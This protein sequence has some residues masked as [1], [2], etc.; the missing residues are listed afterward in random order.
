MPKADLVQSNFTG[1]QIS[2]RLY[3]R[4][5]TT[6]YENGAEL[7]RNV[8][9]HPHGGV[10]K[11][12]GTHFVNDGY[13]N[14]ASR[15]NE[16]H[17]RLVPFV[18]SKGD[19]YVLEYV[20]YT[21][22]SH[23]GTVGGV[24]R[25]YR[26]H[27]VLLGSSGQYEIQLPGPGASGFAF[28]LT[29]LV[30]SG[31]T[32]DISGQEAT[33]TG[34]RENNDGTKLY[35]VGNDSARI[36]EYEMSQAGD[37]STAV[38]SGRS[39]SVA[40]QAGDP[41]GIDW[42]DDGTKLFVASNANKQIHQYNLSTPF[43]ITTA[44]YSGFS[45]SV[46]AQGSETLQDVAWNGL[47]SKLY[48]V[49]SGGDTIH[50]YDIPDPEDISSGS[51]SGNVLDVSTEEGTP[52]GIAWSSDFSKLHVIGFANDTIFE[53]ELSTPGDISTASYSGNSMSIVGQDDQPTGIAWSAS[54]VRLYMI[55]ST[56]G[57]VYSYVNTSVPWDQ[58][59][60][61][62]MQIAQS[63]DVMY[64]ALGAVVPHKLLRNAATDWEFQAITFEDGPYLDVN[65]TDTTLDPSAATGTVNVV[66]S[67][68]EGI[69]DGQGFLS[70]DVGR[71]IRI[72]N[73]S[74]WGFGKITVVNSTTDVT[75]EVSDKEGYAAFPTSATKDWRLGAWSDT[76][77]YPKKISFHQQ[78]LVFSNTDDQPN[79]VWMS[80]T[81]DF[82]N[83]SPTDPDGTVTDSH[84]VTY[85]I[86]A[87]VVDEIRWLSSLRVLGVGT[88][89]SEFSTMGE[90]VRSPVTPAAL[91]V[92]RETNLGSSDVVPVIIDNITVFVTRT[93]RRVVGWVYNFQQDSYAI[94]DLTIYSED[95]AYP[96]IVDIAYQSEPDSI[97][98]AIRSDGK[99]LGLTYMPSQ[100][101]TAWHEHEIAG[102]D[103]AV[104]SIVVIPTPDQRADELWMIVKRTVNGFVKR[105]IEYM[106]QP[107]SPTS[108]IEDAYFVDS[109]LTY[110]GPETDTFSGLDH[111]E[112]EQVAILADG[113]PQPAET[114]S[115]G[116]VT[117]DRAASKVA[118][119][120]PYTA[121][122]RSLDYSPQGQIAV[123]KGWT[124]VVKELKV[125]F[126]QTVGAEVGPDPGNLEPVLFRSGSDPMSAPLQPFSGIKRVK[127]RGRHDLE[128]KVYIENSQPLPM[129]ILA[130]MPEVSLNP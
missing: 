123:S 124:K 100:E 119:G 20:P 28:N 65:T 95:I 70:T 5:D 40:G 106:G 87:G 81:G 33:S 26:N 130:L 110:E 61:N 102:T 42:N 39:L 76:T 6:W 2:P 113:S 3:A 79:T 127:Y 4:T 10:S 101:V 7:L 125:Q 52:T 96:S 80:R 93:G 44:T 91:T 71:E 31:K 38:Y 121:S 120:L 104:E 1:G 56:G 84:A 108:E 62:N 86:A 115:G 13:D 37:L 109:G 97:I 29:G 58:D 60:V 69:N 57:K 107:F 16:V 118:I 98:W 88:A 49:R 51:Y 32:L 83:F 117:I 126:Y 103:P 34:V 15:D 41:A 25:F 24:L 68:T 73:G 105:H 67:S 74:N 35:V 114:V 77:G 89:G 75:V 94:P 27:G 19:A 21:D 63:A 9:V 53:Y 22:T 30:Y 122:I 11:R 59:L 128:A 23:S 43:L 17:A 48:T 45:L 92:S 112:G 72:Q 36:Y 12:P 50:E 47:H 18:F 90:G 116:S 64:H 8:V 55:G 46:G 66:A 54:G 82:E 78:R 111:L 99:L 129:T 85:S 14:S